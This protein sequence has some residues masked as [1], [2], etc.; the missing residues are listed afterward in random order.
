MNSF[1]ASPFISGRGLAR[2]TFVAAMVLLV[3]SLAHAQTTATMT[4][5]AD[6]STVSGTITISASINGSYA[7]VVFWRDN[8]VQIGQSSSSQLSY[9]TGQLPNGSHQFFVSVLDSAGNTPVRIQHRHRQHSEL[10]HNHSDHDFANRRLNC[11]RNYHHFRFH[12]RSLRNGCVLARQL[13][14]NWAK[15]QSTALLQHLH[16]IRWQPPVLRFRPGFSRQHPVR[17]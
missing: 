14:T 17:L 12:Q 5:P 6:G 13:G 10:R 15:L 1:Y 11:F 4:S 2:I 9:N 16:I 7:T 3:A 8:W